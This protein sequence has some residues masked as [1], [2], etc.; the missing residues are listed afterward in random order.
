MKL[1]SVPHDGNLGSR[2]R[3]NDEVRMDGVPPNLN[4]AV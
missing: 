1:C 4:Y 2:V 3:G